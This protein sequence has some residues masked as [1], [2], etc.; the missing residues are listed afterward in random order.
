[1]RAQPDVGLLVMALA[2]SREILGRY[3]E[4]GPRDPKLTVEALLD[5]LDDNNVV[6][7][8]DRVAKSRSLRLVEID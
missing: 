4:P 6:G 2:E 8:L 7:A 1:M 5:V 3:I